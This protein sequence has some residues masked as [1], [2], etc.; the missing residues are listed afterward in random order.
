MKINF[1]AFAGR[2]IG[3][4]VVTI[5]AL[6]VML[7]SG[8]KLF[9]S[10]QNGHVE[11]ETNEPPVTRAAVA[12]RRLVPETIDIVETYTGMIEPYERH[13]TSFEI[14]GRI[15]SLGTRDAVQGNGSRAEMLDVGDRVRQGQ[16]LATLDRRALLA[17][18]QETQARREEA[19]SDLQRKQAMLQRSPGIVTEEEMQSLITALEVATAADE[20]AE[21][22]LE[23]AV[24]LS[25]CDGVIAV[26]EVNPGE[27]VNPHQV[28]FEILEVDRLRLIVG[29]PQSRLHFLTAKQREI[30]TDRLRADSTWEAE[31]ARPLDPDEA[32]F[33]ANVQLLRQLRPGEEPE[34]VEGY[35]YRVS[36][37]DDQN[38]GLFPVEILL[39]NREGTIRPGQLARASIVVEE[40]VGHRLPMA[41]ALHRNGKTY[42]YTVRGTDDEVDFM[43]WDV[44]SGKDYQAELVEITEWIEQGQDLI[45]PDM[46]DRYG[47]VVVRGQHRLVDKRSVRLV[48]EAG[49]TPADATASGESWVRSAEASQ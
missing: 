6:V 36:E 10:P 3:L 15:E 33:P 32:T 25:P 41:T 22:N 2:I 31:P 38:T 43:F 23:D 18:K 37:D 17:H 21:K 5:F 8:T 40:R 13:R 7:A 4:V 44:G 34:I 20:L 28:I 11:T 29:V 14:A 49:T 24:L 47:S 48:P 45:L 39:D 19:E 1:S 27:T 30:E 9:R 35:V 26:R 42:I 16:V 46:S 12:V